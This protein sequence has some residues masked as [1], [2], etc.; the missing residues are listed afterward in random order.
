MLG[1]GSAAHYIDKPQPEEFDKVEYQMTRPFHTVFFGLTLILA[2]VGDAWS[3]TFALGL[4]AGDE[5]GVEVWFRTWNECNTSLVGP[6][7]FNDF[8]IRVLPHC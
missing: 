7:I 6:E 3:H 1:L 4:R 2:C 8:L 5:G